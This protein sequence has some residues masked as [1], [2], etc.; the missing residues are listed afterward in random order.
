MSDS[1]ARISEV[2]ALQVADVE[3]D[4]SGGGTLAVRAAKTDQLG[5]GHTRYLGAGHAAGGAP[6]PAGGRPPCRA[7]VPPGAPR[8]PRQRRAARS[9]QHPGD[10]PHPCRRDRRQHRSLRR[11]PAARWQR[12]RSRGRRRQR[13]RAAAGRRLALACHA[14]GLHQARGGRTRAGSALTGVNLD[15]R[16]HPGPGWSETLAGRLIGD[17]CG[18]YPYRANRQFHPHCR[19][20]ASPFVLTSR[21]SIGQSEVTTHLWMSIL[22]D[23]VSECILDAGGSAVSMALISCLAL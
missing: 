14:R 9:R 8:R 21:Y 12:P 3:E 23:S 10:H 15:S 7:A 11:A 2:A 20:L 16:W 18:G 19:S 5:S 17:A 13:R 22:R 6:L 1:L 4:A